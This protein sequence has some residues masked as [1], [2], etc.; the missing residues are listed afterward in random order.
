MEGARPMMPLE[1]CVAEV[2]TRG[3][4][5]WIQ[6]AEVASVAKLTGGQS[7][8]SEI[9]ALALSII[10]DLVNRELM[11]PGGCETEGTRLLQMSTKAAHAGRL[12]RGF[13]PRPPAAAPARRPRAR[14]RVRRSSV[15][16]ERD[17]LLNT[18]T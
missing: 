18:F 7:T 11:K 2:L 1:I 13:Q 5:D 10:E 9:E 8:S 17:V 14:V 12:G 6:A 3:L 16:S 4:D 15:S